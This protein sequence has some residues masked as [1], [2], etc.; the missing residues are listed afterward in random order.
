MIPNISRVFF[1]FLGRF[2]LF[3]AFLSTCWHTLL[4]VFAQ[5][6]MTHVNVRFVEQVTRKN[7]INTASIFDIRYYLG[8]S[9]S[10]KFLQYLM[11]KNFVNI[12]ANNVILPN[13]IFIGDCISF[14]FCRERSKRIEIG[15]NILFFLVF[16]FYCS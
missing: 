2:F 5:H 16:L 14:A 12:L 3:L 7:L 11:E 10:V 9:N 1:L 6:K 4:F 8:G 13:K 15:T